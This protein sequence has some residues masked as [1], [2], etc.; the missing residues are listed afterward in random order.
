[1]VVDLASQRYDEASII[2]KLL[3]RDPLLKLIKPVQHDVD[4][5]LGG[6]RC[7]GLVC[8]KY[9]YKALSVRRDV[10]VS[11]VLND[12]EVFDWQRL[13]VS[14]AEFRSSHDIDRAQFS[15][16]AGLNRTVIQFPPVMRPHR[17]V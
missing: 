14:E 12:D 7:S 4:L 11:M 5:L 9:H 13:F 15:D 16:A 8:W 2:T 1:M 10:V 6:L 3:H 17:P